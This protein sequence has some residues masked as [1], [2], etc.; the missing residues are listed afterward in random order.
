MVG[1]QFRKRE[2]VLFYEEGGAG[3]NKLYRVCNKNGG[4]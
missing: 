3:A 2:G 4:I 1:M